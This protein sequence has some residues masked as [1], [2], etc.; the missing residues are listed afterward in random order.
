MWAKLVA[1]LR[2]IARKDSLCN[3]LANSPEKVQNTRTGA[4]YYELN[5]AFIGTPWRKTAHAMLNNNR[6]TQITTLH[7]GMYRYDTHKVKQKALAI[8]KARSQKRML[9]VEYFIVILPPSTRS[10]ERKLREKLVVIH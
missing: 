4:G 10:Q 9:M 2:K 6:K 8:T 7:R 1:R 3:F 5:P